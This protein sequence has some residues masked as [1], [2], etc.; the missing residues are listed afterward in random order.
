MMRTKA[1]IKREALSELAEVVEDL[2]YVAA[3]ARTCGDHASA[4]RLTR[5]ADDVAS[6]RAKIE[7]QLRRPVVS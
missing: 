4:S 1:G 7:L 3:L 6:E 5:I 2:F